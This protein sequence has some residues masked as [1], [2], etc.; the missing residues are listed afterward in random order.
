M[1]NVAKKSLK[2]IVHQ[3][4]LSLRNSLWPDLDENRLW[5]RLTTDGWLSVPR[6]LPLIMRI[7]D[8]LAPKGKPISQTYVD[9]WCRT[10]EDSFV[11][12]NKPKEMAFYS[13]FSGER[14]Q[15]TWASRID[16][17]ADL[18]FIEVK[19][20]I[21]GRINYVLILNPY[22]VIKKHFEVGMVPPAFYNA[23][24]ERAIEIGAADLLEEKDE[25]TT[26]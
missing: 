24:R 25:S 9:L 5:I 7:M 1:A 4:K 15:H 14:S 11:I 19:G 22:L 20:G 23:L 21:H 26:S 18:G 10:F 8:M 17:L 13:G 16:I 6:P 2:K 3:K 12:V